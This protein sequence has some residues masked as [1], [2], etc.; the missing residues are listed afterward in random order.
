MMQHRLVVATLTQLLSELAEDSEGARIL[1]IW[2]HSY[3]SRVSLVFP[4]FD[5]LEN[6]DYAPPD[7]EVVFAKN[8]IH[9]VR[10]KLMESVLNMVMLLAPG[11]FNR[12]V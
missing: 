6:Y 4:N 1:Q 7:F 2:I 8:L 11:Q 12:E 9:A 10:Y 3:S 5:K